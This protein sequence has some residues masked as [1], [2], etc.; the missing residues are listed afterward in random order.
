MSN[1]NYYLVASSTFFIGPAVYGLY[2]GHRL[3]PAASLLA[4]VV[5]I[6]YWL[7]PSNP[8]K[9]DMDLMVSKSV[10][11]LFFLNGYWNVQSGSLRLFGYT[12]VSMMIALYQAS[13][14]FYNSPQFNHLWIPCH[15]GFHYFTS[16]G[17]FIVLL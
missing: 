12:N 6:Q 7:D 5:S 16:L 10:G 17:Q 9:R 3:L 8:D 15:I 2:K 4:T 14:I 1:S 11:I 13:C